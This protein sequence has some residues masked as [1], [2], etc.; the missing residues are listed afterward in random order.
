VAVK[1]G[2]K[3]N[4]T[5]N[6]G[7]AKLV[8][9]CGSDA[10]EGKVV[11]KT[12]GKDGKRLAVGSFELDGGEKDKVTVKLNK[13]ARAKLGKKGSVKAVLVVRFDD[14]STQRVKVRLTR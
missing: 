7:K 12:R 4:A 8:L 3:V 6:R 2:G 13:R 9:S 11:L 10:C 14:G 5:K 1:K